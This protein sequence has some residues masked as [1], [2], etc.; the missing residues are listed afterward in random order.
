MSDN[1]Y[2]DDFW[3]WVNNH[4]NYDPI[5]LR[6]NARSNTPPWFNDALE[7]ISNQR[8]LQSK[9]KSIEYTDLIPKLL[10]VG[11]SLEQASSATIALL[12]S[13]L[14][15][16]KPKDKATVL[17]MT[18]G[19]GI[20]TSFFARHPNTHVISCELNNKIALAAKYNFRNRSNITILEE[21]SIKFLENTNQHF[22]LIF[23]DPARRDTSGHRVYNIHD[24][25][26]DVTTIL[27]LMQAKSDR[28]MIKLSPML[29][30]TQTLKDLPGIS[31]LWVIGERNECR[32]IL[33]ILNKQ[34]ADFPY[35]KVWSDSTT[36]SFTPND[37]STSIPTYAFPNIDQY[38][39]EPSAALMKAA[40]YRLICARFNAAMIHPNTHLYVSQHRPDNFPG[41]IYVINNIVPFSSSIIKK[42]SRTNIYAD[43]AVR[44]FPLT[45][46]A[47][48]SRLK[49]KKSGETRIIGVTAN[50]NKQYLLFIKKVDSNIINDR[51]P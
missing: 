10:I 23:I 44:N 32:E 1:L 8:R 48:R 27:P 30:I 25:T 9:F 33:A 14:S 21:N 13:Q 26:P 16:I 4:S 43:V 22:N 2:G 24:C 50:D 20:D 6:L 5:K 31:E 28:I 45:A 37:E 17:D 41:Q 38:V 19:L 47:L 40:P 39:L 15:N 29:D 49:I 36:F 3:T 12:H 18:C 42:L 34:P 51:L 11:I 46:D 7:Q 35:I